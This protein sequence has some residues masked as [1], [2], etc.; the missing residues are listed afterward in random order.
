MQLLL[1]V[2][3]IFFGYYS[4][5]LS[6]KSVTNPLATSTTEAKSSISSQL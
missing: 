4:A 2:L 6:V 3:E 1:A 5:L